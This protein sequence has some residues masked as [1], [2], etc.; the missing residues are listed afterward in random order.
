MIIP[1]SANNIVVTELIAKGWEHGNIKE[2]SDNIQVY[3]S[4][5]VCDPGFLKF[6]HFSITGLLFF[7]YWQE[8]SRNKKSVGVV[9]SR[10]G[11]AATGLWPESPL[12]PKWM[13]AAI[14]ISYV[15]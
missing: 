2:V 7:F 5:N 15:H 12:Y 10:G 11:S 8:K 14:Q 9:E 1:L 3:G 6:R 13:I 4:E